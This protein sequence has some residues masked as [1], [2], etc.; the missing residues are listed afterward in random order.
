MIA[1]FVDQ[2]VFGLHPAWTQ[3]AANP[4]VANGASWGAL[5]KAGFRHVGDHDDRLGP[6]RLMARYRPADAH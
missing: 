6:C 5:A 1:A 4:F 2:V 3:V